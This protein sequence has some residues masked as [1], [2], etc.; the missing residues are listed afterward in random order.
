MVRRPGFSMSIPCALEDIAS[1]GAPDVGVFRITTSG[2]VQRILSPDEL[3]YEELCIDFLN[4]WRRFWRDR[5]DHPIATIPIG[6]LGRVFVRVLGEHLGPTEVLRLG[7]RL[8]DVRTGDLPPAGQGVGLLVPSTLVQ[9]I[10]GLPESRGIPLVLRAI[11]ASN[12]ARPVVEA[13]LD[14][15][16]ECGRDG[17]LLILAACAVARSDC[18]ERV[19]E[20]L[21]RGFPALDHQRFIEGFDAEIRGRDLLCSGQAERASREFTIAIAAFRSA[22]VSRRE[23]WLSRLRCGLMTG[24]DTGEMTEAVRSWQRRGVPLEAEVAWA[25]GA[26]PS[27]TEIEVLIGRPLDGLATAEHV[28]VVTWITNLGSI[29]VPGG[30]APYA[31]S[32][33]WEWSAE[34]RDLIVRAGARRL[35][36][37][38]VPIHSQIALPCRVPGPGRAGRFQLRATLEIGTQAFVAELDVDCR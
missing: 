3:T 14:I 13:A 22:G 18:R 25:T 1:G 12:G 10:L 27:V 17:D 26:P 24:R 2:R 9:I 19:L 31:A 30:E 28:E 32:L 21:R 35:P 38:G 20:I 16:E 5:S 7:R 4:Q 11:E 34:G 37:Y 8:L 33:G 36:D 15:A 23:A 6:E 29:H